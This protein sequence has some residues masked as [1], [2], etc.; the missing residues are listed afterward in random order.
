MQVTYTLTAVD[1]RD[2]LIAYRNRN[3]FSHWALPSLAFLLALLA[4]IQ[5]YLE[6]NEAAPSWMRWS[7]PLTLFGIWTLLHCYWALPRYS[8]QRQYSNNPSAKEKVT[9]H[10]QESGLR[11][12]TESGDGTV[13]WRRYI[14]WLEV[15]CVFV[16]VHTPQFFVIIPKRA[17]GPDELALF[18]QVLR[19]N[20]PGS[21]V[22]SVSVS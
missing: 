20:I 3:L 6:L 4:A 11:F 5:G 17:F 14:K 8:A 16:L 2:A 15:E 10:V 22:P 9:L 18:K 19:Q 7:L 1:F 21:S 12:V 13:L